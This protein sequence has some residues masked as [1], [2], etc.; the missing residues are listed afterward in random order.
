MIRH[1]SYSYSQSS[2]NSHRSQVYYSAINSIRKY[3]LPII[4]GLQLKNISGIGDHLQKEL[5]G[6]IAHH[7]RSFMK[8][9]GKYKF[10]IVKPFEENPEQSQR[11]AK[12]KS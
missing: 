3:P 6:V 5:E 12:V 10:D 11:H 1:S 2:Y 7:Y 9:P 4:C 8:E